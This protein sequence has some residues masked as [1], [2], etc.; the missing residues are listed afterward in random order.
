MRK[1]NVH[2]ERV[3]EN[4]IGNGLIAECASRST[5]SDDI[6]FFC[7]GVSNSL[8][9]K[10]SE[11]SREIELINKT[12]ER[13]IDKKIVY[14]SS[15]LPDGINTP[16]KIHKKKCE[17]MFLSNSCNLVIRIPT[18][19]GIKNKN[20]LFSTIVN[21][22]IRGE[23]IKIIKNARRYVLSPYDLTRIIDNTALYERGLISIQPKHD[24]LV[25]KIALIVSETI[26]KRIKIEYIKHSKVSGKQPEVDC[27]LPFDDP[28]MTPDY[29]AQAVKLNTI[30]ALN[31]KS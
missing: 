28:I 14:F 8:E 24:I 4:I 20:T 11:F 5:I 10:K 30:E 29:P 23:T 21:N 17:E 25:E 12:K 2:T 6:I 9:T 22:A 15:I 31:A 1:C 19:L 13:F 26:R 7:S 18:I 3:K 27:N 16:Y